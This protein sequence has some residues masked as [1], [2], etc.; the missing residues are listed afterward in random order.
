[1]CLNDKMFCG[2]LLRKIMHLSRQV[3]G[4]VVAKFDIQECI[5]LVQDD[6]KELVAFIHALSLPANTRTQQTYIVKHVES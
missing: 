4:K 2:F 5:N 3:R 1:M 6:F